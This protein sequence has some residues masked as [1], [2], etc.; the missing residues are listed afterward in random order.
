MQ[1][2]VRLLCIALAGTSV[3]SARA[4]DANTETKIADAQ[5]RRMM[6]L[7]AF[8]VLRPVDQQAVSNA[9]L[10]TWMPGSRDLDMTPMLAPRPDALDRA[11]AMFEP[12]TLE[13]MS[14]K[15][16]AALANLL[17]RSAHGRRVPA[18]CFAEG[19]PAGVIDAFTRV[20]LTSRDR[21]NQ[22][23]RWVSTAST[24]GPTLQG[25]RIVLTYSF[26]PDGTLVPTFG[27]PAPSNLNAFLDGL[28]GNTATWRALYAQIFQRWSELCGVTYVFEPA[29]DGMPMDDPGT[30]GVLGVRGDCRLAGAPLDG[31]GSVLAF[32]FLPA[33]DGGGDMVIDT[34]DGPNFGS[35]ANN[36][37]FLR[38]V[39]AHEHGHGMGMLHVCPRTQNKLME[40]FIS[41]VFDGP[42]LDDILNGQRF[43]GDQL[44][45]ND[46]PSTAV[47]LP[48]GVTSPLSIDGVGDTDHFSF[49]VTAAPAR[50]I[51]DVSPLGTIYAE[52]PQDSACTAARS[53]NPTSVLN[54]AIDILDATGA[55]VLATKNAAGAGGTE[56]IELPLTTTGTR[57]IRVRQAGTVDDI[58][59]YSIS[60]SQAAGA[61]LVIDLPSGQPPAISTTA[62]TTF[63]VTVRSTSAL[64]GTPKLFYRLT[65][66]AYTNVDLVP[67]GAN[68][69][70]ATLPRSPF[71]RTAQFYLSAQSAA[72]GTVTLPAGA[73]AT[74]FAASP[75]STGAVFA[76]DFETDRGW[77]YGA[78]GDTATTGIWTRDDPNSTSAQPD[79]TVSGSFC[80]FTGASPVGAGAG[81]NDV[82]SGFTT[83]VSPTINLAGISSP[84]VSYCRWFSNSAGANPRTKAFAIDISSD[85]GTTWTNFET[86][87]AT[88]TEAAGGWFPVSRPVPA[89]LTATMKF[90]FIADDTGPGSVIEAAIDDFAVTRQTCTATCPADVNGSSTATVQDI[91]DFL[92]AWFAGTPL[93]DFSGDNGFTVQ[94]IFDYLAAWFTGC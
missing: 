30:S 48:S 13:S 47:A 29:D 73:P 27:D 33:N 79:Q 89:P 28:Y 52:G 18:M 77:T 8:G 15:Q 50:L 38:N 5:A 37:R 49:A 1:T 76:D 32:N 40:P 17:D 92:N 39:L 31:V 25:D 42:Q 35:T 2:C 78:A 24:P 43:Y 55:T 71:C 64:V 59:G 22:G 88:S 54:L 62:L 41:T 56:H 80:A 61:A 36:S 74:T 67:T 46:T 86:V 9:G 75:G 87:A 63:P 34:D 26:V 69:Y 84:V 60:V 11:R 72:S 81:D 53:Y 20:F 83:L 6:E 51:V 7:H 91:F 66:G 94:D 45:P 23:D 4:A 82:D 14:P 57:L 85:N 12:G 58:Q 44:E 16:T 19:T 10:F 21:F 65:S 93:G 70:S 3:L 90:R 68:T